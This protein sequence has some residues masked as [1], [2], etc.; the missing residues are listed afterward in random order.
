MLIVLL[1]ILNS[2]RIRVP[3][4]MV[5][6]IIIIIIISQIGIIIKGYLRKK[7]IQCTK[8][9]GNKHGSHFI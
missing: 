2:F 4:D 6:I 1:Q 9:L 7:T 3:E 5:I 8:H